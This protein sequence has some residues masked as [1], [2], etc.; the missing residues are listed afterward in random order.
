MLIY[1]NSDKILAL[2]TLAHDDLKEQGSLAL[3]CCQDS[4]AIMQHRHAFAKQINIPLSQF[5][6]L[7][8]THS[9]HFCEV[10][11]A[12][13]GKGAFT[14]DDALHDYDAYYT[15]DINHPIGIFTADCLGIIL[16]D[17]TSHI[18]A[19]I[20]SGWA[21]TR[22]QITSKVLNHLI[23]KEHLNPSTTKVYMC[24]CIQFDSLE[25]GADILET[26]HQ[27]PFDVSPFIKSISTTKGLLDNRGLNIEMLKRCGILEAN[28]M[29]SN[30]DT[31]H[32]QN[33]F[34]YRRNRQCGRH[35]TMIMWKQ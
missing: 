18:I 25:M 10:T 24:P 4:D 35:L 19:A 12:D 29:A 33:M 6:F 34:S 28:I 16:Y 22:K 5:T 23:Q 31:F 11:E 21:G 32:D 8:Q 7:N 20:H 26:F 30:L 3:H 13:C 17:E 15:K 14:N 9:D 27:L 2:T 1:E